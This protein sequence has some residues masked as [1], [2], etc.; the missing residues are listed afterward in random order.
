MIYL[1]CSKKG[2][3]RKS[4]LPFCGSHYCVLKPLQ[5]DVFSYPVKPNSSR[6]SLSFRF[7]NPVI[8]SH[9]FSSL[10]STWMTTSTSL[11]I[12]CWMAGLWIAWFLI[13]IF[14]IKVNKKIDKWVFNSAPL[15]RLIL[16][17]VTVAHSSLIQRNKYSAY[18]KYKKH[19][20]GHLGGTVS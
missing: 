1:V 15:W 11:N 10:S 6:L 17:R 8:S 5:S 7:L 2:S 3:F 16:L 19:A 9:F 14:C 18:N 13:C 12:T 20:V 4:G